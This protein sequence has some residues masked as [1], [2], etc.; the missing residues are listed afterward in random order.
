VKIVADS[1]NISK[2]GLV[3]ILLLAKK[4]GLIDNVVSLLHELRAEGYW[5]SDEVVAVARKLAEE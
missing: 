2:I 5:L 3:G 1:L 4:K